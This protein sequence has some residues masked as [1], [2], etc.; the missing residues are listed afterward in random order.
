[1]TTAAT[2]EVVVKPDGTSVVE[3]KGFHGRD[4]M[5]ASRFLE[6]ALGAVQRDRL[7]VEFYAGSHTGTGLTTSRSSAE[8]A[9]D[10]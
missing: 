10:H 2:I 7:T 3:T 5:A 4:C 8:H 6:T 9:N 1:M